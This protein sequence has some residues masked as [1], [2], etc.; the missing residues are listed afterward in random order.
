MQSTTEFERFLADRLNID[1]DAVAD[2]SEWSGTGNTIGALALRLGLL[3]LPQIDRILDLQEEDKRLFG[4]LAVDL[5]FLTSDQVEQLVTLQQF[6]QLFEIGE[7]QVVAGRITIR[8]LMQIILEFQE[9]TVVAAHGS[10]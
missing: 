9:T 2:V 5:G 8:D 10:S 3:D 6:H 7:R 4:E 1:T